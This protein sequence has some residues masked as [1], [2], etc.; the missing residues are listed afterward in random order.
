MVAVY[1]QL[2]RMGAWELE[3]VPALWRSQV[4]ARLG[5]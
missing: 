3:D 1:V 2:V 4:E 5:L